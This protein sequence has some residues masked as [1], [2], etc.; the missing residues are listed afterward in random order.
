MGYFAHG[1][2][3]RVFAPHLR[4]LVIGSSVGL[5]SYIIF[6]RLQEGVNPIHPATTSCEANITFMQYLT[7]M[8]FGGVPGLAIAR[9]FLGL[10]GWGPA[11][12]SSFGTRLRCLHGQYRHL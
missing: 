9:Y 8:R 10:G 2:P 6:C 5:C 7:Y 11:I 12:K 3:E 1:V 4:D